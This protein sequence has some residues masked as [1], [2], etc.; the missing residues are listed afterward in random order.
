MAEPVRPMVLSQPPV[1]QAVAVPLPAVAPGKGPA[2]PSIA[3]APEPAAM[4]LEA[5][6]PPP[7][8]SAPPLHSPAAPLHPP[9]VMAARP[10][11]LESLGLGQVERVGRA[12]LSRRGRGRYEPGL[13]TRLSDPS[14][15]GPARKRP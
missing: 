4:A 10:A 12:H 7:Q 14:A 1:F 15:G 2:L 11:V 13:L 8:V 9:G 5:L 6:P 3:M